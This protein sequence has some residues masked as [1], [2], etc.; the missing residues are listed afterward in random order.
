MRR[1]GLVG[2]VSLL[3]VGWL[4]WMGGVACEPP[5]CPQPCASGQTCVAGKCVGG[6]TVAE[7]TGDGST[8]EDTPKEETEGIPETN[9]D[10]VLPTLYRWK[11]AESGV[12]VDL[13]G[14]SMVDKDLAWVVGDQG[15]ILHTKNGGAT[16][17]RQGSG[18]QA[19]LRSVAFINAKQGWIVG[20][21]GTILGTQDGGVTWKAMASPVKDNLYRIFFPKGDQDYGFAVGAKFAILQTTDGGKSWQSAAKTLDTDMNGVFFFDRQIGIFGGDN[22]LILTTIDGAKNFTTASTSTNE[23]INSIFFPS[24]AKGWAVGTGGLFME[25]SERGS[26]WS[27]RDVKTTKE[28]F[29][30]CFL[31]PT[32]GWMVGADGLLWGTRDGAQTWL[33][34]T[35]ESVPTLHSISAISEQSGVIVGKRGTIIAFLPVQAEC[36]P[37]GERD[38]YSGP[39]GTKGVGICKSGKQTC[40]SNGQWSACKGEVTP[41]GKEV[42]FNNVDDNC[43]GKPDDQDGCPVCQD[44]SKQVCYTDENNKP[45]PENTQNVGLCLTGEQVCINGKWGECVGAVFPAQEECNGEDDDCDGQVDEASDLTSPPACEKSLG[46]CAGAKRICE[47]GQ[48]KVCEAA[49]YGAEY[50][51][52]EDKCDGKDNDCDGIIDAGCPCTTEGEKRAC[53]G[54]DTATKGVGECKDGAQTCMGGKWSSCAGQVLPKM[55]QCETQKDENCNGQVDERSQAALACGNQRY[56][57][58]AAST[59]FAMEKALTIEGWFLFSSLGRRDPTQVL[60]SRSEQGGYSLSI[61]SMTRQITFRIYP[62]G[63]TDYIT[64]PVSYSGRISLNRWHHIA[65]S[66]DGTVMRLWIDGKKAGE[67]AVTTDIGYG[68]SVALLICAEAGTNGP[69]MRAPSY[70]NGQVAQVRISNQAAYSADFTPPCNMA[71]EAS[72]VALWLF[73]EGTGDV[74][75]DEVGKHNATRRAAYWREAVRCPGFVAGGCFPS[76]A[77]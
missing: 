72:T 76:V 69:D 6:E 38:C 71:K 60:I 73:D 16:W 39:E 51:D 40:E 47:K 45:G 11:K 31:S 65:A 19:G 15:T 63:G 74:C 9:G 3:C 30:L 5:A 12:T 18:V 66:Y 22:G 46:V 52:K 62:K 53:Y 17:E 35:T 56:V 58:V 26:G 59:D 70:L 4:I 34:E 42:C 64:L 77:P 50:Q 33:P 27:K 54:G 49:Q 14:A 25:G 29:D 32:R 8:K 36:T 2:W 1:R 28:L 43:N 20:M 68:P 75:K 67:K 21:A 61:A 57:Q 41:A 44:N 23:Y 48:W 55:E 37:G 7:E 24:T 13:W 10:G